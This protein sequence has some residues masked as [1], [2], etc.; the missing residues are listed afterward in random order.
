[1]NESDYTRQ[2]RERRIR[3]GGQGKEMEMEEATGNVLSLN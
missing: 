3:G 2:H 1:M